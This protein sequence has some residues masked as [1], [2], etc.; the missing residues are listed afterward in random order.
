MAKNKVDLTTLKRLVAELEATLNT[1]E[2]IQTSV[3]ADKVEFVVEMNKAT[4]LAAG[5]MMESGLLMGDIQYLIG[6]AGAPAA[7]SDFLEK[8]LGGLKGPGNTN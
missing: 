1:A 2:D 3:S 5:I 6:G 4:G 7:K 8:I